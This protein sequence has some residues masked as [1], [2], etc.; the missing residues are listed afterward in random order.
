[1][2]ACKFLSNLVRY[3]LQGVRLGCLLSLFCTLL[4]T[5]W[6]TPPVAQAV[7]AAGNARPVAA[8]AASAHPASAA[9]AMPT[10]FPPLACTTETL[11]P[12]PIIPSY[13]KVM[14]FKD[15]PQPDQVNL[16][17]IK[18][19]GDGLPPAPDPANYKVFTC[20]VGTGILIAEG[21]ALFTGQ[22]HISCPIPAQP[23]LA[24]G[25]FTHW[26]FYGSGS[27]DFVT[28]LMQPI[29][30]YQ[31]ITSP[32]DTVGLA[33]Q[34]DATGDG[35]IFTLQS[36]TNGVLNTNATAYP[37]QASPEIAP[38]STLKSNWAMWFQSLED[39]GSQV[40]HA[41]NGDLLFATQSLTQS[42]LAFDLA[43][44]GTLYIGYDPVNDLTFHGELW[45]MVFDP[46]SGQQNGGGGCPVAQVELLGLDQP[47]SL[48]SHPVV[49]GQM[50]SFTVRVTNTGKVSG[51]DGYVDL[52]IDTWGKHGNLEELPCDGLTFIEAQYNNLKLTDVFTSI[53]GSPPTATCALTNDSANA[54]QHPFSTSSTP[55]NILQM[56]GGSLLTLQVPGELKP[57]TSVSIVVTVSIS[58]LAEVGYPLLVR[59]RGGFRHGDSPTGEP[60]Y[61]GYNRVSTWAISGTLTPKAA[62]P[63]VTLTSPGNSIVPGILSSYSISVEVGNGLPVSLT[64]TNTLSGGSAFYSVLTSTPRLVFT[65][66]T[67][68]TTPVFRY[69]LTGTAASPDIKLAFATSNTMACP[70]LVTN[71]ITITT[72]WGKSTQR[73][74]AGSSTT[75]T[76]VVTPVTCVT[77]IVEVIDW[78]ARIAPSSTLTYRVS[79][80]LAQSYILTTPRITVTLGDGLRYL[81]GSAV[82]SLNG[83]APKPITPTVTGNCNSLLVFSPPPQWSGPI[84]GVITFRSQIADTYTCPPTSD[85]QVG[86]HD[87]LSSTVVAGGIGSSLIATA[88]H[89]FRLPGGLPAAALC[90]GS[91]PVVYPGDPISFCFNWKSHSGDY[92]GVIL[93]GILPTPMF[94]VSQTTFSSSLTTTTVYTDPLDN[95]F[96]AVLGSNSSLANTP[97]TWT[98]RVT[99][100][101]S[102]AAYPDSNLINSATVC[103]HNSQEERFCQSAAVPFHLAAPRLAFTKTV[104]TA[105]TSS[106]TYALTVSNIGQGTAYQINLSDALPDGLTHLS[107]VQISGGSNVVYTVTHKLL[108]VSVGQILPNTTLHITF[109]ANLWGQA[110]GVLTNT[111]WVTSYK[112]VPNSSNTFPALRARTAWRIP[113]APY[114]RVHLPSVTK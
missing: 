90:T 2:K 105:N 97:F 94:S 18:F 112:A 86:P 23:D 47:N 25:P 37:Y 6:A 3:G 110:C 73:N 45:E 68:T 27:P 89:Q 44:G 1:M 69:Q 28:G 102:Q 108:N 71:T 92:R 72:Y 84:T 56:G 49:P 15:T 52:W 11:Y 29:F 66:T 104:V 80:Q 55:I 42:E 38:T 5:P 62:L 63:K 64:L 100:T 87:L 16:C 106:L 4:P 53:A 10:D 67:G 60:T 70:G 75:M 101:V 51:F 88:T 76:Q 41:I 19:P 93:Q 32:I 79:T 17:I 83:A 21:M 78:P 35:P 109:N 82:F 22:G 30:Y 33:A 81:V 77:H 98:V 61:S 103:E 58:S 96:M 74:A 50:I 26:F 36:Q 65:P 34:L 40:S 107:G 9:P 46:C 43:G 12:Y 54:V 39:E 91:A 99:T 7:P 85:N 20:N 114:C 48:V 13:V 95:S 113:H 111:A 59:A 8:I 57:D 14:N 31:P 24:A